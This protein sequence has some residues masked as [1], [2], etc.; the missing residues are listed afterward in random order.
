M[1]V[2]HGRVSFFYLRKIFPALALLPHLRAAL[3]CLHSPE[4]STRHSKIQKTVTLV[5][6]AFHLILVPFSYTQMTMAAIVNHLK[7]NWCLL[8]PLKPL[9]FVNIPIPLLTVT[10]YEYPGSPLFCV[11]SFAYFPGAGSTAIVLKVGI[12]EQPS[13]PRPHTRQR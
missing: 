12:R 4:R 7:I 13:L 11:K 6:Q 9:T 5:R 2:F 8:P 10:I 3:G 1:K